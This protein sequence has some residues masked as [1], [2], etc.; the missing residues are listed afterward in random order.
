MIKLWLLFHFS[1]HKRFTELL[2]KDEKDLPNTRLPMEKIL[3]LP[4]LKV[5]SKIVLYFVCV[6]EEVLINC[7]DPCTCSCHSPTL[8]GKESAMY[9]QH[10]N[11]KMEAS[12][13][14]T[15]WIF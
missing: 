5:N 7:T 6:M 4:E 2:S 12:H 1:A 14:R 3:T 11:K 8:S 10:L 15:F 9:S 13:L